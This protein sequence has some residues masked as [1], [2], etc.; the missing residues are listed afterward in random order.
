MAAQVDALELVAIRSALEDLNAAFTHHLDHGEIEALVDLFTED[1]LYTH[2]ERR[3][4]GRA[5]IETLF[6]N[7]AAAGPRTS[8]HIYSGLTFAIEDARRATGSSVCLTFAQDGTPPLPAT[9]YLVA[10]FDDVYARCDD[11]R[12]RFR[13]RHITRIFVDASNQGPIGQGARP[14]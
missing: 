4:E 3:S 2:G 6:Q 13:E 14:K 10:D 7:R 12:W 9:P 11:G 5:E 1:A 8:R